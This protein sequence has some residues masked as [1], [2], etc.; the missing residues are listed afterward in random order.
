MCGIAGVYSLD[1]RGGIDPS[2][3]DDMCRMIVHRGPDDQGT[4]I[5]DGVQIGMRRLSIIDLSTGHQPIH[6]EDRSVWVV[7]NGEIYNFKELRR[8]LER[9]GH[10]FYTQSDSECIVHAYEEYAEDCFRHFRGMFG[11]AIVDLKADK[12]VLGRDR[13]GKKPLYYTRLGDGLLGFASELKSLLAVPGFVPRVDARA[14][15]DYFVL[16]YVPSPSS[17][18]QGVYKLPPAHCLVAQH[19]KLTLKRYWNLSFEPKLDLPEEDLKS[20][21]RQRLEE[22][23]RVRLVSDVPFG[24]FLSGGI[25]SS[26]VA[27]LM[28]RNLDSPLKTFTIG[29]KEARFSEIDDARAVARHLGSEHHELVVEAD[30]VKLLHD[31]VWYFDEPFGDSSAIPTYLVSRLASRHV[32][33]VLSGDGGDE[34]FVGYERYRKYR[35]LMQL[36]RCTAGLG[37]ALL[38]AG[39]GLVGGARGYR[40]ERIAR[41]MMQPFPDRYLSGVGLN[42]QDDLSRF[43]APGVAGGDLYGGVRA[44]FE[45]PDIGDPLD[46]IVAGDLGSYLA[47][48]ILV[49]VDRM[50][51]ANSLEAR[52]PLLDHELLEFAARLPMK[53]RLRGKTGK[54]LL[55]QVAADLLPATVMNKRKQGFAIPLAQWLRGEL[56]P[57][58]EDTFSDRRFRERG[59]FDVAGVQGM[60]KE[61]FRGTRDHAEALW[62]LLTYELWARKFLD[63]D[64]A[65]QAAVRVGPGVDGAGWRKADAVAACQVGA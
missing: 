62:L 10:T 30:A 29:F 64:M 41:R 1:G 60:L 35:Q 21:L 8:D 36:Q 3:V 9:R 61:H 26:V 45:R 22:A 50:T 6:N 39:G 18:Y 47:D 23:V 33:M 65:A 37:P 14:A 24:A 58:V 49:K 42:S 53:Y 17:I 51:M 25:D 48:D 12:L 52:A 20:E 54:Y 59:M 43:L 19:G 4:F 13:L 16:G 27:A 63:A 56:R 34:L 5:R 31:L 2:V 46:R 44:L 15:H 11:I 40:W 38:K 55:K 57:L 32:K 7:F 28:A